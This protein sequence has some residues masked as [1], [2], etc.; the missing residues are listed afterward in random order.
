MKLFLKILIPLLILVILYVID[1]FFHIHLRIYSLFSSEYNFEDRHLRDVDPSMNIPIGLFPRPIQIKPYQKNIDYQPSSPFIK[2]EKVC[3]N[4]ILVLS[5]YKY[6]TV[7]YPNKDEKSFEFDKIE[8]ETP[9]I[10]FCYNELFEPG[11]HCFYFISKK[12]P[13]DT[14]KEVEYF[15]I[16]IE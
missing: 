8:G 2:D 1:G 13:Q 3:F 11:Y 4:V 16:E 14:N 5:E 7:Q 12:T 6:L 10:D 15:T 9:N